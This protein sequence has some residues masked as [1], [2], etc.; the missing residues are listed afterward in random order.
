MAG[1]SAGDE[2]LDEH[3]RFALWLCDG[4]DVASV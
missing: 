4:M 1:L 3:R 2:R